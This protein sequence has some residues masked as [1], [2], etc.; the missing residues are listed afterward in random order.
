M[1]GLTLWQPWASAI[2]LG[3]KRIETRSWSVPNRGDLLIHAAG[4]WSREQDGH[5]ARLVRVAA[6]LLGEDD[7]RV[8]A[9]DEVLPLGC[10]V[11]VARL[12]FTR[13]TCAMVAGQ[14]GRPEP[15]INTIPPLERAFGDFGPDRYGWVLEDVRPLRPAIRCAGAQGLWPVPEELERRVLTALGEGVTLG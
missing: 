14:F 4:K 7:P 5:K 15:W 1:R 9:L 2:A 11:A 3:L 6:E 8:A 12:G 13:L 10:A